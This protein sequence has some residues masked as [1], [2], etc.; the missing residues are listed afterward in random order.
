MHATKPPT[1][2]LIGLLLVAACASPHAVVVS[3]A[4]WTVAE[5]DFNRLKALSGEWYLTGGVRL[6][7]EL[8]ANPDKAFLDY[9]VSSGGHAVVEKLFVDQPQEMTTVYYLDQGQLRMDHYCSLGNQPRMIAV[10]SPDNEI[11]FQLVGVDNMPDKN[12]LHIS[13]HSLEFS[14]PNE[15]TVYWG[16]TE[17]QKDAGGSMYRVKPFH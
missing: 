14:G 12:D 9:S 15:L 13:S 11:A 6:G 2:S 3:S 5:K 10:S 1:L 17:G 16:A 7:E 8:E 4:N